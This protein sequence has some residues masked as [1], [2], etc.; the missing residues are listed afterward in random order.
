[1]R[2]R[3][4]LP[5]RA[6]RIRTL[7]TTVTGIR[8]GS[9]LFAARPAEG[10]SLAAALKHEREVFFGGGLS[11]GH[12]PCPVYER[13]LLP[14]GATLPGPAIVEQ[15]DAT[16]VIEPGMSARVDEMGNLIIEASG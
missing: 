1:M 6:L 13:G 16:T 9:R 11:S 7:N 3:R 2:R 15:G 8:P 4:Y 14:V 5:G 10:A 12:A